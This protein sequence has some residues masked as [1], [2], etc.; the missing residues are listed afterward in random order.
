MRPP[1]VFERALKGLLNRDRNARSVGT[2][3]IAGDAAL[4]ALEREFLPALLE[5]EETP[6]SPAQRQL[7]WILVTL[8]LCALVW[9]WFG[10]VAIVSTAPGKFIPDGRVK[11]LQPLEAAIVREIH[12]QDGQHVQKGELLLELDPTINRTEVEADAAKYQFNR[13]EQTRLGAEL[14]NSKIPKTLTPDGAAW[15]RLEEQTLKARAQAY[16]AKLAAAKAT[17]I[18]KEQALAAAQATLQKYQETTAIAE[19][20]E[21]S[22][23]PLVDSGALSRLDYLQLKQAFEESGN[24]LAAQRET[25]KQA[26]A[27]QDEAEQSVE[28]VI[29]DRNTDILRLE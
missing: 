20:R 16:A 29:R 2:P 28:Q 23:R 27:A 18:E 12:V 3:R 25:V 6:P 7:L 10:K 21:S 26:K 22:A 24:D 15:R 19:E 4:S 14:S 5:I 8:V 13:L 9:S 1:N 17:V 11:Q